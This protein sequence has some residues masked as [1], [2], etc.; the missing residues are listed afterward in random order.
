VEEVKDL[1]A[2]VRVPYSATDISR[3]KKKTCEFSSVSPLQAFS[4]IVMQLSRFQPFDFILK[5]TN[6]L[7]IILNSFFLLPRVLVLV[8][9][10]YLCHSARVCALDVYVLFVSKPSKL[11]EFIL[12]CGLRAE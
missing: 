4:Q 5:N 10:S 11:L 2:R 6:T 9:L 12:G 3:T 1:E 8:Y 7:S